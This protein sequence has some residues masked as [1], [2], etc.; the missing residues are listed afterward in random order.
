MRPPVRVQESCAFIIIL[1]CAVFN[2]VFSVSLQAAKATVPQINIWYGDYQRFGH[3]GNPQPLINILGNVSGEVASLTC[4]LNGELEKSLSLGCNLHR[5][6]S[7]GDFNAEFDHNLLRAGENTVEFAAADSAGDVTRKSVTVNYTP[8]KKW[9]LPYSIDWSKVK[10]IQEAAQVVDG[11]WQ[12][13]S[14]GVR[15]VAPYYDRVIAI[16]D[17]SWTDYE[18]LLTV[19][20]NSRPKLRDKGGAPWDNHAHASICLRWQGHD[21]DGRQPLRKWYPLGGL[22][23]LTTT[24]QNPDSLHWRVWPGDDTGHIKDDTARELVIGRPYTY[25]VRVETLE[26]GGSRYSMKAWDASLVEE[27]AE[28]DMVSEEGPDDLQSGSLLFVVHHGD[29]TYGDISITPLDN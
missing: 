21:N 2:I 5:L 22:L 9:P 3:L 10:N 15:S 12:L 18:A 24:V 13:D 28:W 19:T 25:R 26:D 16:G 1:I 17:G 29:V 11:Y 6:A 20:W 27:P 23:A 7:P 14:T 4:T 8:G